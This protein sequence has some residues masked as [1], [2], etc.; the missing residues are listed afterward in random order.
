MQG[1]ID[2][3]GNQYLNVPPPVSKAILEIIKKGDIEGVKMEIE[4]YLSTGA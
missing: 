3:S 4:K 2:S 1:S